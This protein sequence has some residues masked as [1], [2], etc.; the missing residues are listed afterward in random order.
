MRNKPEYNLPVSRHKRF[1]FCAT[2][3]SIMFASMGHLPLDQLITHAFIMS[4]LFTAKVQIS[5]K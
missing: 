1:L 3:T 2:S 5:S 4:L